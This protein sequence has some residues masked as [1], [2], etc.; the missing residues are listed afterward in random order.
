[1]TQENS[2]TNID[3]TL[4][5]FGE[6]MSCLTLSVGEPHKAMLHLSLQEAR[7]LAGN[8]IQHVHLAEVR[9]SLKK[10]ALKAV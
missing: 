5:Q 4:Q 2:T 3:I 10:T 8:L 6:E 1:M 7:K 9:N